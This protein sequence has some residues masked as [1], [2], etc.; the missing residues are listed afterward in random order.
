MRFTPGLAALLALLPTALAVRPYERLRGPKEY[1]N[2]NAA[3][4][5][6]A[7]PSPLPEHAAPAPSPVVVEETLASGTSDAAKAFYTPTFRNANASTFTVAY[8]LPLVNFALQPSWAGRLPIS[9]SKTE[10]R[11]LFFWYWPSSQST[12]SDTLTIWL[13]GGMFIFMFFACLLFVFSNPR[14]TSAPLLFLFH[15]VQRTPWLIESQDL[16]AAR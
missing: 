4:R 2:Q 16:A 3:A 11:E 15:A 6:D 5:G 10:S 14:E 1:I 8:P 12:A 7:A 9:G 13:N